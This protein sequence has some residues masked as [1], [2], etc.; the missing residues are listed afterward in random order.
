VK[1][2]SVVLRAATLDDL[3]LIVQ[4]EQKGFEPAIRE[5][6][7]VFAKRINVFPEGALLGYVG[8]ACVGCFFSEI[9]QGETLAQPG[10]FALGHDIAQ[11]HDPVKGTNLYV[12]SITVDPAYRGNGLGARLFRDCIERV[13]RQFPGINAVSLL[14]SESWGN[15]RKIYLRSGFAE[16]ARLREFFM[17]ADGGTHDGIV[18]RRPF[19]RLGIA[20]AV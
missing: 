6:E 12:S 11:R 3:N 1:P 15:A 9:W 13:G 4:L 10:N 18:M 20:V 2:Q 16:I 8:S 19:D 14:V 17:S 5:S 7:M